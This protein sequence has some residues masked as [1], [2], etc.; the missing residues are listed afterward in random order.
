MEQTKNGAWFS[1][2]PPLRLQVNLQRMDRNAVHPPGI[3][4]RWSA[5]RC[6]VATE[7]HL[8]SARK[9]LNGISFHPRGGLLPFFQSSCEPA[10]RGQ[11]GPSCGVDKM[12]VRVK[13]N[14]S[15]LSL[16]TDGN[17][18]DSWLSEKR[19]GEAAQQFSK[20]G[21]LWRRYASCW[22]SFWCSL[23]L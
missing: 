22:S 16:D 19:N 6:L 21:Q 3:S 20:G 8:E 10:R 18:V 17:L 7:G 2:F 9:F 23:P 14:W 12:Y 13:G 15:N 5:S 11:T 1:P 4:H